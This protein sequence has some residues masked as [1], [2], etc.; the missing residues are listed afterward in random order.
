MALRPQDGGPLW[1][2]KSGTLR[3][4][5]QRRQRRIISLAALLLHMSQ[6]HTPAHR[7]DVSAGEVGHNVNGEQRAGNEVDDEGPVDQ[8][9]PRRKG[10]R[11]GAEDGWKHGRGEQAGGESSSVRR[12]SVFPRLERF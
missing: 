8:V 9:V 5:T 6:P 3:P 4:S 1:L 2:G 11:H 12:A 7:D 10:H